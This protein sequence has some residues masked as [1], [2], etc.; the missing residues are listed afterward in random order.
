MYCMFDCINAALVSIRYIFQNIIIIY[1][2]FFKHLTALHRISH[3]T[4]NVLTFDSRIC[5][6]TEE[7][8]VDSMTVR[9]PGSVAQPSTSMCDFWDEVFVLIHS[10]K[11]WVKYG[12]TQ[13]LGCL[14]PAVG[15]LTEVW[16]KHL[17]QLMVENN[18]ACVLSNIYPEL[19]CI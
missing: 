10:Q 4:G 3:S 7:F 16:I 1:F 14:D 12:W 6:Y 5:W 2:I 18:P 8:M 19:C 13:R 17:T 15:L 9:C 11:C